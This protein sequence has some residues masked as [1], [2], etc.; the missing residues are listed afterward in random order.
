MIK[1]DLNCD[2]GESFGAYKI[3]NDEAVIPLISSANVAC[4]FHAGD[5][6]VMVKPLSSAVR[7]AYQSVRIPVFRTLWASGAG[8]YPL[9]LMKFMH[10]LSIRSAHCAHFFHRTV[11]RLPMLSRTEQCI[12]WRQKARSFLTQSAVR[13]FGRPRRDV[14]SCT[15]VPCRE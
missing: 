10:I 11:W 5:A 15:D 8:T 13:S 6:I 7:T 1:V 9:R 14:C 3:G 12:I 4:G 2:L